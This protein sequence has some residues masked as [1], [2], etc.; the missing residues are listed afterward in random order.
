MRVVVISGIF[1]TFGASR[2]LLVHLVGEL[3]RQIR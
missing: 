1:H 3:L 2:L